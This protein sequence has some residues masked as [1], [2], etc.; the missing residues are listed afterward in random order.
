MKNNITE[1]VFILD[2]SGSM[3]GMEG[4]TIGGFNSIIARQKKEEGTAY[5]TTVLFSNDSEVIHDRLPLEKIR[6]MTEKDYSVGGC[7]ALL[8]SIGSSIE[9]I[10][11]IHRYIRPEDVPEKTM[12]VI[13]TDGLENASHKYD[14]DQVRKMVE[15]RKE[16][17][18]EFV[19]MAANI[20]AVSAASKVGI[21]PE[22]AV[23]YHNDG[24]GAHAMYD[25]VCCAISSVR[26]KKSLK[27]KAWRE[28][29][30]ADF[31]ARK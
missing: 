14:A 1:L 6:P 22:M 13:T 5:V 27:N 25:A 31:E 28:A 2:R 26:S 20:D 30:D 4:D 10:D 7:T 23:N 15:A 8:D 29:A 9:K 3:A 11:M 19:F 17:G 21:A 24:A 12:F 18:W 16:S